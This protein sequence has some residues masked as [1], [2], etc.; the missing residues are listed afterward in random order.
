MSLRDK[1]E[2]EN[3]L[4]EQKKLEEQRRLEEQQKVEE[5][6]RKENDIIIQESKYILKDIFDLP[7]SRLERNDK[8]VGVINN[9][10]DLQKQQNRKY[11]L[12]IAK[13]V[14]EPFKHI[15]SDKILEE[16]TLYNHLKYEIDKISTI[17]KKQLINQ[18]NELPK[19]NLKKTVSINNKILIVCVVVWVVLFYIYNWLIGLLLLILFYG[20]LMI[21]FSLN[22]KRGNSILKQELKKIDSL[23]NIEDTLIKKELSKKHITFFGFNSGDNYNKM[24]EIFGNKYK[25]QQLRTEDIYQYN[26]GDIEFVIDRRNEKITTLKISYSEGV[27]DYLYDKLNSKNIHD[28]KLVLLGKKSSEIWRRF[29]MNIEDC[30]SFQENLS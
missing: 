19:E 14:L 30:Y 15:N 7:L 5:R 9:I 23:I 25:L 6:K 10:K 8:L 27:F 18:Q 13:L 11:D 12:Q 24:L 29:G 20:I 2:Q 26:N 21:L 28:F 3:R 22:H 4:K 17:N 1:I 16:N